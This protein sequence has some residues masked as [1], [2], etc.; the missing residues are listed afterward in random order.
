M[1]RRAMENNKLLTLWQMWQ[2]KLIKLKYNFHAIL[3]QSLKAYSLPWLI[4]KPHLEAFMW[5]TQTHMG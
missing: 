2:M 1:T 4:P 3:T 5:I